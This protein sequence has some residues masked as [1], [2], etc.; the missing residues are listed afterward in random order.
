MSLVRYRGWRAA[1]AV[2]AA[3]LLLQAQEEEP[4][5][6]LSI[7]DHSVNL[8][9]GLGY[10]DNVL[11]SSIDKQGSAFWQT[12]LDAMLLR[13]D[14]ESGANLTLFLTAEDRRYFADIDVEKEQLVLMQGKYERPFAN[15]DWFWNTTLQY[16]YIDQV[17]DAS[18]TEE[19]LVTLPVK[20]HNYQV[21]PAIG[22]KLPW[23]SELELKFV[24]ERQQ[25]NAP[26][27]DY[28]ELGPQ[29]IYT[30]NYGHKSEATASYTYDHRMYDTRQELDLNF[31]RVEGTELSFQQ[32]EFELGL[33]HSWD[34]ERRWRSR[35]RFL[36]EINSDGGTGFYDYKR[37][38]WSKRIGY[39]GKDWLATVE[40]RILHYDYDVQPVFDDELDGPGDEVRANWEYVIAAHAEKNVWRKLSVFG[41]L[42]YEV[43]D[44]NYGAEEYDVVTVMA[45]VDWEF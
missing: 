17:F 20:S 18:A 31:V 29:L 43:V 4:E 30:K 10:K 33:N 13:A 34:E 9:G 38:R 39:Y 6:D 22:R 21:A 35:A 45:G 37:Y 1:L 27:D 36:F 8:R 42:E 7:W 28:W 19:L 16:M 23:E 26:L 11:L 15:D 2:M 32:H 12:A 40:G 5:L 44:S 24:A 3:P 14:L 25:F 41:D